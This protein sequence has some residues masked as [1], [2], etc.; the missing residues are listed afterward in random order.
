M[1]CMFDIGIF[2]CLVVCCMNQFRLVLIYSLPSLTL[3]SLAIYYL[4]VTANF[5]CSDKI[6]NIDNDKRLQ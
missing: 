1:S 6:C 3:S 2:E 4:S 5:S